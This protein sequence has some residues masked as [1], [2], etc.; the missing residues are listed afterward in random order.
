MSDV[1]SGMAAEDVGI[2]FR[3]PRGIG[4]IGQIVFEIFVSNDHFVPLKMTDR[5]N[6]RW[7]FGV[8]SKTVLL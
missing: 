4:C 3:C 8:S 1:L 7:V 2:S 5:G 6:R